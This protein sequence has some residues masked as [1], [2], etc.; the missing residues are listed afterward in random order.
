MVRDA[1]AEIQFLMY[2]MFHVRASFWRSA[3]IL[4]HHHIVV[5]FFLLVMNFQFDTTCTSIGNSL[6][7]EFV[8]V[9]NCEFFGSLFFILMDD[10]YC[11]IFTCIVSFSM[12]AQRIVSATYDDK[13]RQIVVFQRLTWTQLTN[14]HIRVLHDF[15]HRFDTLLLRRWEE[16]TSVVMDLE[17]DV[18][19][20]E[21]SSSWT[22]SSASY[23]FWFWVSFGISQCSSCHRMISSNLLLSSCSPSA[24]RRVFPIIHRWHLRNTISIGRQLD[25]I[26]GPHHDN[27]VSMV[28]KSTCSCSSRW[29]IHSQETFSWSLPTFHRSWVCSSRRSFEVELTLHHLTSNRCSFLF[30]T[31]CCKQLTSC[32]CSFGLGP[33]VATTDVVTMFRSCTSCFG[34]WCMS[35]WLQWMEWFT[36]SLVPVINV[37]LSGYSEW[38]W[39]ITTDCRSGWNW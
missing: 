5:F 18:R 23:C 7:D 16:F 31:K 6:T 29:R 14:C 3:G 13:I 32:G 37:L 36:L 30:G 1:F 8:T 24:T 19:S 9:P 33:E 2:C 25:Y 21:F 28:E 15:H 17:M 39:C 27:A 4:N 12:S 34:N 38:N 11:V 20:Y 26:L 22:I 35:Q 10:D